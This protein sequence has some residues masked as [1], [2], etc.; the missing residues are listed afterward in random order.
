[1]VRQRRT[2]SGGTAVAL[3]AAGLMALSACAG[4]GAAVDSRPPRDPAEA[5]HRAAA[6][7]TEAGSSR[8]TTSMEMATGGTRVTIRGEGVYDFRRALGQLRVLLPQDPA[9][10]RQ[11]RPLTELL[12]PGALYM[13]NRGAGVPADKWVRIET[14]SL[15]D[16]N[17]VT[18]GA[19]D[20]LTAAR[21]LRGARGVVFAG[22]GDLA[23]VA[24]RRYRGVADLRRAA[25]S[26]PAGERGPL[27]AA[28]KG[29]GSSRVPFEVSLDEQGR[30]RKLRHRFVYDAGRAEPVAVASTLLL[31]AFGAPAE[32]RLPAAA[33]I[34]AGKIAE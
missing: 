33:D 3:C 7:L 22:S 27:L 25:R 28:A 15:S 8:A 9:G 26:L 11:H 24:V 13:K 6:A 19:T 17:L 16:G 10:E 5:V 20:P 1:M 2:P 14:A 18:G 30:V 34:Y 32:V 4:D 12:S 31:Y 23:G 21:I 29:F